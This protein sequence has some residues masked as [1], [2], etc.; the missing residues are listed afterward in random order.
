MS[1]CT[2][3][4]SIATVLEAHAPELGR[5]SGHNRYSS[6]HEPHLGLLDL[7]SCLN[8]G[9]SFSQ[10]AARQT[11]RP[12]SSSCS[13]R[14]SCFASRDT[15]SN[16]PFRSSSVDGLYRLR[17][18]GFKWLIMRFIRARTAKSGRRRARPKRASTHLRCIIPRFVSWTLRHT[19]SCTMKYSEVGTTRPQCKQ[20]PNFALT[21]IGSAPSSQLLDKAPSQCGLKS[22]LLPGSTGVEAIV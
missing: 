8:S 3:G 13:R 21:F 10:Y 5:K 15:K 16:A 19:S 20:S 7:R 11:D 14:S 2:E 22:G 12:L 1:A 18:G 17:S 6:T 9:N 4:P